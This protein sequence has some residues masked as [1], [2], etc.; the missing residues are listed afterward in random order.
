MFGMVAWFARNAVA[1]NLL[2]V[3]A[4]IG[5]VLGFNSMERELFPVVPVAGASVTMTWNGASP[6]DVEEQIITRIEEAVADIDG[7]QRITSIARESFAVVNIRGRDD[8]DMKEY[9]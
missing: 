9:R 7:L 2:M 4:F 8:I 1:A 3:V 6:Q 5:G